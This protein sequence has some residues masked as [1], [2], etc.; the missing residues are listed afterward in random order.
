M[1]TKLLRCSGGLAILVIALATARAQVGSYIHTHP[2]AHPLASHIIVPQARSFAPNPAG[3]VQITEVNVGVEVL[4]Q[5]ATT[6][7]DIKFINPTGA[8]LEAEMVVPVPDGAVLRGFTFQGS[9]SE[10]TAELLRKDEARKIYDSIVAKTKD[11]A[12][13]EF[14]G[15]NLI[16]SSVFPERVVS[17]LW[18]GE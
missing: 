17:S 11:P 15:C 10:P 14:V 5:V 6:T 12:L 4:E 16:R 8:R 7:M 18:L 1:T 3:T 9:A 2:H 13:L